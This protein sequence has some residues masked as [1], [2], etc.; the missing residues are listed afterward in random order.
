MLIRQNTEGFTLVELMVSLVISILITAAVYAT[1]TLQR[2]TAASQD[3]V[4]EM[5]QNLRAG[6][7]LMSSEIKMA[8][9]NPKRTTRDR[10]CDAGGTGKLMAPG[11]HTAT[12]SSFGFSMDLDENGDCNGAGENV[13]YSLY[14]AADGIQKLGRMNPTVNQAVAENIENIEFYYSLNDGTR[15]LTPSALELKRIHTVHISMLALAAQRD[16]QYVNNRT[17]TTASGVPWAVNDGFKRRFLTINI[18]GRNM[19]M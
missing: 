1:Y 4:T 3:R 16:P 19:G 9:Y 10:T 11:V 13:T 7:I 5:Q 15:T 2:K 8:G 14:T 6:T 17:Y 18:N 12:N